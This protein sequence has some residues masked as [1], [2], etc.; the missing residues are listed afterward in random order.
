MSWVVICEE[1]AEEFEPECGEDYC[2]ECGDCL[3]CYG[4]CNCYHS[5]D[6][7]HV[8]FIDKTR[9]ERWLAEQ[10]HD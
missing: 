9:Y 10:S 3:E 6:G 5:S 7:Q 1:G 8:W 2:E 4:G